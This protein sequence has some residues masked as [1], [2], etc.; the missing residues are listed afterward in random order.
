MNV[1]HRFEK[2]GDFVVRLVATDED[3]QT[4]G[5]T[6]V[7]VRG[8]S[9]SVPCSR[10]RPPW[11]SIPTIRPGRAATTIVSTPHRSSRTLD[12]GGYLAHAGVGFAGAVLDEGDEFDN[13]RFKALG[14]EFVR[15]DIANPRADFDLLLF[16][17]DGVL[18]AA[19]R[20]WYARAGRAHRCGRHLRRSCAGAVRYGEQLP[21]AYRHAAYRGDEPV[22]VRRHDGWHPSARAGDCAARSRG[23]GDRWS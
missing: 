2:S 16:D 10:K 3:D 7:V 13:Y 17:E 1:E 11:T 8:F 9:I 23:F 22:Y 18:V 14:G 6:R 21:V 5:A 15:F 20:E 19:P 4:A 12:V